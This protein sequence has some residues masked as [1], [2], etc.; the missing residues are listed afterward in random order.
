MLVTGCGGVGLGAVQ[1]A[2]IGGATRVIAVDPEPH[3]RDAAAFLGAPDTIDPVGKDLLQAVLN[4]CGHPEVDVAVEA[5]G[6][7]A[8]AAAALAALAPGE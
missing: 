1:A 3:R 5:V 7:V 4:A 6:D 8:L 2:R